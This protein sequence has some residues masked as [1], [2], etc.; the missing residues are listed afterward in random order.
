MFNKSLAQKLVLGVVFD[1]IIIWQGKA[2]KGDN[3]KTGMLSGCL[4]ML[5]S[6][7]K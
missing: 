6:Y 7:K 4:R 2:A 5:M 3:T 1:N